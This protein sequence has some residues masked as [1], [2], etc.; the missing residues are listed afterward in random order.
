MYAIGV[1]GAITVK[2]WFELLQQAAKIELA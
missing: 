1:V 2:S